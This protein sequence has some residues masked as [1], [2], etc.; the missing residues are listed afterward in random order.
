MRSDI[1]KKDLSDRSSILDRLGG[2]NNQMGRHIGQLTNYITD[3]MEFIILPDWELWEFRFV[4]YV[5]R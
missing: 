3:N 2:V 1:I 4:D 5:G